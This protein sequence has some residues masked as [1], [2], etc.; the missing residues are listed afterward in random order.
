MPSAGLLALLD[1]VASLTHAAAQKTAGI[2]GD[3][4]A[5]NAKALHGLDPV[6]ELP[7]VWK[8]AKG[9]LL[10]KTIL[11]PVALILSTAAPW[12]ITPLMVIGGTYL[13][14]EGVEKL[15]HAWKHRNDAHPETE[16]L[17]MLDN[18]ALE[19]QKVR[20]AIRTDL[21]LSA[22]I[23]VVSL[24]AVST[25]PFVTQASA[26]ILIGLIMT[27]GIY[28]LV[29][30]L[31]KLDDI[32]LHLLTHGDWK[33]TVGKALVHGAP[34]LLRLIS[35]LGTVAMFTVGG[36]IVVHAFPSAEHALSEVLHA[37]TT[38]PALTTLLHMA[39]T[40]LFGVV[41]GALYVPV[42]QT[43]GNAIRATRRRQAD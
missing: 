18:A 8:V 6:R 12:A 4:L 34:L 2:A 31:V 17:A 27:V 9:S 11:I 39:A 40:G 5:L 16:A 19:A 38:S 10:N 25:A 20:G 36:G 29:G 23:I 1:D 43:V 22:E 30:G 24:G 28:G 42:V 21:I 15:L 7:I 3:D 35:V 26:L 33:K 37:L 14:F 32:G 13:C 41:L